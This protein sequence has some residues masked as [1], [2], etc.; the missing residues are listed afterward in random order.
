MIKHSFNCYAYIIIRAAAQV[1]KFKIKFPN[2]AN[3]F[4]NRLIIQ[5][6]NTCLIVLNVILYSLHR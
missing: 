5:H 6:I 3:V 2:G 4:P 1:N